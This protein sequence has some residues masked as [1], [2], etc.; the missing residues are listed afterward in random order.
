MACGWGCNN[1]MSAI[2]FTKAVGSLVSYLWCVRP[3]LDHWSVALVLEP[4]VLGGMP[5]IGSVALKVCNT[6]QHLACDGY[7]FPTFGMRTAA[8]HSMACVQV[9]ATVPP[10]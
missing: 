1:Y 6:T 9:A 2:Q 10:C 4:C 3:D 8:L 7:T 5:S